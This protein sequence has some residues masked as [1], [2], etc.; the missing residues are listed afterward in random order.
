MKGNVPR[1]QALNQLLIY[2]DFNFKLQ[3]FKLRMMMQVINILSPFLAFALTYNQAKTHNII[4]NFGFCNYHLQFNSIAC[5]TTYA[6]SIYNA[7]IHVH[8]YIPIQM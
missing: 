4:T 1:A 6:T 7:N 3:K 5:D 8:P 2:G